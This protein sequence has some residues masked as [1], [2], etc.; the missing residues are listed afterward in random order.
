MSSRSLVKGLYGRKLTPIAKRCVAFFYLA[1]AVPFF[2]F[3]GLGLRPHSA[4]PAHVH[5]PHGDDAHRVAVAVA[6]VSPSDVNVNDIRKPHPATR[7]NTVHPIR[8]QPTNVQPT[9]AQPTA[10]QQTSAQP[11]AAQLT[12]SPAVAAPPHAPGQEGDRRPAMAG[13]DQEAAPPLSQHPQHAEEYQVAA[14]N[15]AEPTTAP[16]SAP[17][18]QQSADR[19]AAHA[20]PPDVEADGAATPSGG[21]GDGARCGRDV[22]LDWDWESVLARHDLMWDF[23]SSR[24][25]SKDNLRPIKWLT[26]A[27]VG[28]GQLGA[29]VVSG[30]QDSK[31]SGADTL[32]IHLGRTDLWDTNTGSKQGNQRLAVG[33]LVFFT[34]MTNTRVRMRQSLHTA[35][36]DI[37]VCLLCAFGLPPV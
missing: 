18:V 16:P 34:K 3:I 30:G 22:A 28:N 31:R 11:T 33:E 25:P 19:I 23:Y 35:Q 37:V 26:A 2:L 29:K 17:A 36:L 21:Q 32:S 15:G 1:V 8:G 4:G 24:P 5:P 27:Y 13:P 9:T 7:T 20:Q 10:A 14:Q 12:P 6:A